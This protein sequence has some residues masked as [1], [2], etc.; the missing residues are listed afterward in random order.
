MTQQVRGVT[1]AIAFALAGTIGLAQGGAQGGGAPAGA[2]QMGAGKITARAH[3]TIKGEGVTGTA[4]FVERTYESGVEVEI[5]VDAKGL[6]PG[7]HGMH[8]HAVGKCEPPFTSAG[9][10]VDPGPYGHT[11]PDANHPFHM[12]DIPNL[13]VGGD[14]VGKLTTR[15]TRV[16]LSPG[17]LSVFDEDGTAIIIHANPDQMKTGEPKSGVSGGPRAACGVLEKKN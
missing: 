1:T 13:P 3:A 8:L 10:H 2:A 5:T 16:T 14:G 12:G 4:E 7:L 15:T 9:G 17:P 11:D 6:K